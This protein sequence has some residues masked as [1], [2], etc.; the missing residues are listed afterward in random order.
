MRPTSLSDPDWLA[1]GHALCTL[2]ACSEVLGCS[3]NGVG[4]GR[5]EVWKGVVPKPVYRVG[6]ATV[7]TQDP[8]SPGVNMADGLGL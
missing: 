4:L 8:R 3:I 5:L 2:D 1:P 6:H 7:L